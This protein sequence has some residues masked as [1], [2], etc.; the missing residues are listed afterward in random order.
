M[1]L[2]IIVI[3][4][5]SFPLFAFGKSDAVESNTKAMLLSD[6]VKEK[7]VLNLIYTKIRA[8][9]ILCIATSY[10]KGQGNDS[11]TFEKLVFY[12]QAGNS[13]IKI[14]EF[15]GPGHHFSG[16]EQLFNGD[17]M[18]L[19]MGNAIYACV[20]TLVNQEIKLVIEEGGVKTNPEI[21]DI[22]N[23]G[24]PELLFSSGVFFPEGS[25]IFEPEITRIYKMV[26][27]SYQVIRIVPWK[28]RFEDV[29]SKK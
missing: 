18:A 9:S 17:L 16:F 2:F 24:I 15:E 28:H 13:F 21:A 6:I 20:F 22:D 14:Y 10:K 8:Q 3:I 23:D 7:N 26:G 1:K 25:L 29:G 27:D 11:F 4:F 12:R 19:W 5:L